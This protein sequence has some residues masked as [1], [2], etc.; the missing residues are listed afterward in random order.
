MSFMVLYGS[1]F[2]D[3]FAVREPMVF[4]FDAEFREDHLNFCACPFNPDVHVL[5]RPFS[6]PNRLGVN[7]NSR[8]SRSPNGII[9]MKVA[10]CVN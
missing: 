2:Y 4:A 6:D 8:R 7:V 5:L 9:M 10:I 3:S 1:S